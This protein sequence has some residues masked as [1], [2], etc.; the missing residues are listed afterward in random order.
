MVHAL[1]AIALVFAFVITATGTASAALYNY[2]L[3]VVDGGV[4][5]FSGNGTISFNALSGSGTGGPAFDSFTFSVATLDGAPPG[6]L[7]LVF[8]GSM[9][10]SLQWIIDSTTKT[11]T[12]DL[13]VNTQVD[14]FKKWDLSFDTIGAP[15]TSVTCNSTSTSSTATALS[16]Y[17]QNK[18]QEDVA[19]SL[20]VTFI[21]SPTTPAATVPEPA[22]LALLAIALAGLAVARRRSYEATR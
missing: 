22:P 21:N 1:R 7:P 18:E 19:S 16:C 14:G 9:I 20:L 8:N 11:L 13:D 15:S 17:A 6:Q 10:S 5:S 4:N 2:G 3:T 12:L